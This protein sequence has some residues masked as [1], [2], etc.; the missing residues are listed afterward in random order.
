MRPLCILILFVVASAS[1]DTITVGM[2][3]TV[4]MDPFCG[5]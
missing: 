2:A 1:S 3:E 5:S 4:G